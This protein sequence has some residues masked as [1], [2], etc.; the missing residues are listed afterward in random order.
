MRHAWAKDTAYIKANYM[1]ISS[2]QMAAVLGVTPGAMSTQLSKMDLRRK[3]KA[4]VNGE[5]QPCQP[6]TR[7]LLHT[8]YVPPKEICMRDGAG[9]AGSLPSRSTGAEAGWHDRS[10]P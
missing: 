6:R 9:D 7:D 8:D 3:T 5:G 10:H 2:K 4:K 1:T